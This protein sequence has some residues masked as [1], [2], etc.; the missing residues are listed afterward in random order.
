[1]KALIIFIIVLF[2]SGCRETQKLE[3]PFVIVNKYTDDLGTGI[4]AYYYQDKNGNQQ[5]FSD[6]NTK[7]S[8]G[9]T[10]K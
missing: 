1:M 7:Y 8:I 10:I 9:D 6:T 5:R 4:A 2:L 3:K